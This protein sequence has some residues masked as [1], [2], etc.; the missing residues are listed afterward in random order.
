MATKE[1]RPTK[2]LEI[3]AKKSPRSEMKSNQLGQKITRT[4]KPTRKE[5]RQEVPRRAT[6]GKH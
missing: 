3:V 4:A 2:K 5:I 1:K 6:T